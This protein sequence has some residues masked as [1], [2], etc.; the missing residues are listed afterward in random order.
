VNR[1]DYYATL[2]IQ[3]GRLKSAMQEFGVETVAELSRLTGA[4]QSSI[5]RLL[6]FR[7]SPRTRRGEW[8]S[9]TLQICK[10]L[11]YDP[12]ELFPEHLDHEIPTNRIASFVE[13]SQ[14]S[15]RETMQLGPADECQQS[16]MRQTIDEVLGTLKERERSILK[17]LFWEEKRVEEIADEQGV[18]RQMIRIVAERALRNLRHPTRIDKLNGICHFARCE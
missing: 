8:R 11:G 14:L 16:E 3:Q 10:V 12:S 6:N 4:T 2:R 5:G 18:C 1:K 9:V 15:G 13:R 17:A 7:E